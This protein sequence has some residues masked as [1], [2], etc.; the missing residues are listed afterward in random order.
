MRLPRVLLL[1]HTAQEGGAEQ[2]LLRTAE[3]LHNDGAVRLQALLFAD[4]PLKARLSAVGI[5]TVVLA[6]DESV[7]K[8]SRDQIGIRAIRSAGIAARFVPRLA[9]AIRGSSADVVVANSLKSAAFAF[10]AAPLAGRRWIWHLHDRLA[11]DYMPAPLARVMQ[12]V[13]A[14]GPHTIVA[15]SLATL[16]TLPALA[17]RKAVVVHPGLPR[18]VFTG[19]S[20]TPPELTR[21]GIVGRI[22]PTK[23]QREFLEATALVVRQRPEA[24][25]LVV[26]GALFG[27]DRYEAEL[28]ELVERLHIVDQV[29][30]TGW[31]PNVGEWLRSLTVLVH[32]SP[33]PEPFGQVI[34]EAMAA[35]VPVVATAAGGVLEILAPEGIHVPIMGWRSTR[36]GVLVEPGN[37]VALAQAIESVLDDADGRTCRAEA[38][39]AD[40]EY[41]FTIERTAATTLLAWRRSLRALN[42]ARRARPQCSQLA[43]SGQD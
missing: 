1:D 23:G 10:V 36:S 3:A 20:A 5:P 22:S 26:G 41:R 28:R 38:A 14:I 13:A 12:L 27:E 35:G 40:A 39:R 21:V 37:P 16:R 29:E 17:R 8:A 9:R 42:S 25:F 30:F 43:D 33:V 2:A 24:R 19:R 4:G 6:L 15:N 32:A 31:I 11:A 18:E 34:I 7:A